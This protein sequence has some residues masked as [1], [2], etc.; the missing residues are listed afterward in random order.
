MLLFT[1]ALL[2]R[3]SAATIDRVRTSSIGG[4]AESYAPGIGLTILGLSE[5]YDLSD[6]TSWHSGAGT[7]SDPHAWV[8]GVS[9]NGTT[10]TYTL[11]LPV[12]GRLYENTDYGTGHSSQGRLSSVAPLQLVAEWGTHTATLSGWAHL[13]SNDMMS[14]GNPM[15]NFDFYTA[16]VGSLVPF[17]ATVTKSGAGF[18]ETCFNTS[19][20]YGVHGE[21]NFAAYVVPEPAAALVVLT[22]LTLLRRTRCR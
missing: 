7:F 17:Q 19:F 18:D 22:T 1:I 21:I 8:S 5:W 12:G 20:L 11:N 10:I 4:Y 9:V 3:A 2:S 13:D 15:Q 6:G 14:F 16:P